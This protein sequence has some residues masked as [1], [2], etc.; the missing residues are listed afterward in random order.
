MEAPAEMALDLRPDGRRPRV[1]RQVVSAFQGALAALLVAC[2]FVPPPPL[3][4]EVEAAEAAEKARIAALRAGTPA[5]EGEGGGGGGAAV[6][7]TFAAGQPAPA[8]MNAEQMKAYN[9]AQGDPEA[10]EFTLAEALAGI[11][12]NGKLWAEI[13][14]SRGILECELFEKDAP[15]TVANFVGLARGL[16]PTLDRAGGT[17][18]KK[19]YYDKTIFH[20]VIPGFM[21][22]GGDPTGTGTG[23]PGYVI[24]DEIRP[25]RLHEDAGTLS[26]ANRGPGTGG[27][28][29]F[30]TLG[31]T[32]HLDGK[33]TVFGQC[34]ERSAQLADDISLVP[35]DSNDKPSEDEVIETVRIVRHP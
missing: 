11:S 6:P 5:P 24:P 7:A 2:T 3:P 1:R 8:G 22:Q 15:L 20:R 12:G 23:N 9:A 19:P 28:Q 25:N 18:A 31:P 27:A 16:R 32:P 10:G 14:T 35:R 30:V 26:M 33:H 34:T 21:I 13:V 17:W 29:F 4:E